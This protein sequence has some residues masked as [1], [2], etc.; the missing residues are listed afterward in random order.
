MKEELKLSVFE[1][2]GMRSVSGL[3]SDDITVG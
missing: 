1:N 3:E 2:K